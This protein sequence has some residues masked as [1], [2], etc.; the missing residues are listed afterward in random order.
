MINLTTAQSHFAPV[1]EDALTVDLPDG[2][3]IIVPL[4]RSEWRYSRGKSP[5]R[6]SIRWESA[7]FGTL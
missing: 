5:G 4:A 6:E 7:F 2:R 1:T 3:T